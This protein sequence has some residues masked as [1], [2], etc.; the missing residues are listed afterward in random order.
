MSDNDPSLPG[1]VGHSIFLLVTLLCV[2]RN[3]AW[4]AERTVCG[5]RDGT[6]GN[7]SL[8][9]PDGREVI[10]LARQGGDQRLL[11][12]ADRAVG[13]QPLGERGT[14]NGVRYCLRVR[15]DGRSRPVAVLAGRQAGHRNNAAGTRLQK[16]IGDE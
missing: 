7:A 14:Q 9:G 8:T 4:A 2:P 10:E 15:F 6:A 11:D 16:P 12:E 3:A 13:A 5:V 1:R